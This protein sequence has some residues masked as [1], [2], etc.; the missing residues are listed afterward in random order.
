[1]K[2]I[3]VF[4]GS[5]M[6]NDPVYEDAARSL[7]DV[8]AMRGLGLVYGGAQIGLMG[9]LANRVLAR[10]GNVVGVMPERMISAERAHF[11][12]SELL[13]TRDMHERKALMATRSDAFIALPGGFGTLEELTEI[14]T[15]SQL[16]LHQKPFG[17]L[18]VAGYFDAF[19]AFVEHMQAS[20]FIKPVHRD[21]LLVASDAQSLLD[22]L[23]VR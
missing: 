10:G 17:I 2:R 23:D 4:C 1:M 22:L 12:L 8:L 16:G 7:G 13:V 15:W 6:G 18:N 5:S 3:C 11:G 19:L 14:V 21:M 9:V 20:G